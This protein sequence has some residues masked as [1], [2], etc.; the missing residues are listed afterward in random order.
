LVVFVVNE[1]DI[2]IRCGAGDMDLVRSCLAEFD[3]ID[4]IPG[5]FRDGVDSDPLAGPGFKTAFSKE[6]A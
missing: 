5:T 6:I 2:E 1:L 3:F 4:A